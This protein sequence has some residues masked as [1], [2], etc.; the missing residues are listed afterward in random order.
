MFPDGTKMQLFAEMHNFLFSRRQERVAGM[1]SAFRIIPGR[2][3]E[4]LL[5]PDSDA[6]VQ[7]V[8]KKSKNSFSGRRS[9]RILA[10]RK[11]DVF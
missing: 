6:Q 7:I 4:P 3:R 1:V 10:G 11:T 9:N 8:D 2:Y 5:V